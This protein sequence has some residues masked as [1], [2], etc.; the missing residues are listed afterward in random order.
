MDWVDNH[1]SVD[2]TRNYVLH[3]RK[4][5]AN[6]EEVATKIYYQGKIVGS[7][8]ILIRD[9]NLR[10]GEIG[11]WLD[12]DT[13]GKGIAT[14]AARA[15][16]DYG[17][18]IL[19]LHKIFIRARPDN[20]RSLAIP[21]RLEFHH[22]G[23][24]VHGSLHYGEYF[25]FDTYYMLEGDWTPT[26]QNPEFTY[27]VD[28]QIELRVLQ[29]HHAEAFFAVTAANREYVG[30]WI[31]AV[32]STKTVDDTRAFIKGGLGQYADNDG[33]QLGIWYEGQ[34]CGACGY[35]YWD[36]DDRKTEIGYWLAQDFTGRGIMT[37]SVKALVDYAFNVLNLHRVEIQGAVGNIKSC[38]IPER[39][40]FIH[41]GVI[42]GGQN[43]DGEYHDSNI[44]AI[45]ADEWGR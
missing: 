34:L 17:F 31:T 36:F 29:P 5:F 11:Y 8:G 42:R 7:V 12:K 24:T 41:E 39:L 9:N 4:V 3:A 20:T 40:G 2:D 37:R 28:D 35:H 44:Y 30:R 26:L 43:L 32:K 6:Q 33:I 23:I 45:L 16:A 13:T 25:D 38:A 27:K 19:G 14:R 10:F 22:E 21:K 15:M 1:Q 18:R